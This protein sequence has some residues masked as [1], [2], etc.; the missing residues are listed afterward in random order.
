M[1]EDNVYSADRHIHRLCVHRLRIFRQVFITGDVPVAADWVG[2]HAG[3]QSRSEETG[4]YL[5]G[6]FNAG[7]G[8]LESRLVGSVTLNLIQNG[9][10]YAFEP[11]RRG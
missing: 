2:H 5:S 8:V 7:D 3:G 1:I 4:R 10:C 6:E 11:R 9:V